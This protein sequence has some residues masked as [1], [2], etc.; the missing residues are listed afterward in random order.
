MMHAGFYELDQGCLSGIAERD[1]YDALN[2]PKPVLESFDGNPL[3][4]E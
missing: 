1:N 3:L 4:E 2:L